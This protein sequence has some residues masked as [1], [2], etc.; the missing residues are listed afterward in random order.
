M[1]TLPLRSAGLISPLIHSL[2]S[3]AGIGLPSRVLW[4]AR[5]FGSSSQVQL[6]GNS[7]AE[8]LCTAKAKEQNTIRN[9]LFLIMPEWLAECPVAGNRNMSA[10][11]RRQGA[12][13]MFVIPL[14]IPMPG[15]AGRLP[16]KGECARRLP[17]SGSSRRQ[18]AHYFR[19]TIYDLRALSASR[20]TRKS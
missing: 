12:G 8:S 4:L 9:D 19:L 10:E 16:G 13:E 20:E 7:P 15:F 18:E 11:D 1:T 3:S 14:V 5:S 17:T 2:V 6:S